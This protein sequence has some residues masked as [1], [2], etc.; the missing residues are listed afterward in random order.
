MSPS[1]LADH[2]LPADHLHRA[3]ARLAV[4]AADSAIPHVV[5][6]ALLLA[7]TADPELSGDRIIPPP[8][9]PW[10]DLDA[11]AAALGSHADVEDGA[12]SARA[13]AVLADRLTGPDRVGLAV[14]I[15]R[16]LDPMA[17]LRT[18]PAEVLFDETERA[19]IERLAPSTEPVGP[20][21]SSDDGRYDGYA[22]AIMKITRLCNLRCRY[23][24]DWRA[25]PG[26]TKTAATMAST[27]HGF[28]TDRRTTHLDVALH[29]GEPTMI[30]RRGLLRLLW[31]QAHFLRP[32]QTV[33]T[34]F[35]TNGVDLSDGVLALAARYDLRF[36]VSLD[37]DETR[38]DRN[39][40]DVRG[41]ACSAG[42]SSS[43]TTASS[44]GAPTPSTGSWSS[45]GSLRSPFWPNG[46]TTMPPRGTSCCRGPAGPGSCS[47]STR[48]AEATRP[49][50][51]SP[52][53][54][55]IPSSRR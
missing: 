5:A 50:R 54:N 30:G 52:S 46:P 34:G 42:S 23:C 55:S 40:P 25:G 13:V 33:R 28:L 10:E 37:L 47:I 8:T 22:M 2:P 49:H 18:V 4:A 36:G 29:G 17:G 26:N 15:T 41:Q 3:A 6:R 1:A 44:V 7:G 35:Q 20:P 24:H 53:A 31:L 39:R 51:D 32:G 45:W 48:P 21:A 19:A 43:L 16:A 9:E 27:I 12:R 14:L 11:L 38:H